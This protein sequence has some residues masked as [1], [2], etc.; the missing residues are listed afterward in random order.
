MSDLWENDP[1]E[2]YGMMQTEDEEQYIQPPKVTVIEDYYKDDKG[3]WYR[4]RLLSEDKWHVK[5]TGLKDLPYVRY[6][7]LTPQELKELEER[8][9]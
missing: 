9:P 5:L 1:S 4:W 7:Y 3:V 6:K 2:Y 8:V